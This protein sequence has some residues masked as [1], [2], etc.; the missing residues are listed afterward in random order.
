[1][2]NPYGKVVGKLVVVVLLLLRQE[3]RKNW[4]LTRK[5]ACCSKLHNML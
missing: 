4:G 3:Q 1:M 2:V 5:G